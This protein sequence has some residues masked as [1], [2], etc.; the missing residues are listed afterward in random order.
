MEHKRQKR[1]RWMRE[2]EGQRERDHA[3]PYSLSATD[4]HLPYIQSPIEKY[5]KASKQFTMMTYCTINTSQCL[6]TNNLP[7]SL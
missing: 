2:R 7:S 6:K 3:C 1:E 5:R 4:H